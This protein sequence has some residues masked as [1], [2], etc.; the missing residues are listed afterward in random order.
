[1]S[2]KDL[3]VHP[4]VHVYVL[5]G[6]SLSWCNLSMTISDVSSSDCTRELS[7]V[8]LERRIVRRPLSCKTPLTNQR[9]AQMADSSSRNSLT[10][11][12]K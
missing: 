5:S 8:R 2:G 12:K 1:V 11:L 3:S 10:L 6:L 4:I 7:N 9:H